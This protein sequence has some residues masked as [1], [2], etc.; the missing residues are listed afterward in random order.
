MA[1]AMLTVDASVWVSAFE[2]ADALHPAARALLMECERHHILL[3]SPTIALLETARAISRRFASP[4]K[5]RRAAQRLAI[6]PLLRLAPQNAA[7]EEHA[8]ELGTAL[9]LRDADALYA[10]LSVRLGADLVTTDRELLDRTAG[11][12]HAWTPADWLETHADRP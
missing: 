9:G 3:A 11:H 8:L 7:F 4:D 12:V 1:V 10:A 6:S 2:P 5:G